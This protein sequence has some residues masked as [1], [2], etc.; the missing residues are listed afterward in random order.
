VDLENK[1]VTAAFDSGKVSA[2]LIR[3]AIEDQ[4]YDVIG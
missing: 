1:K 3:V 4:G 2:D